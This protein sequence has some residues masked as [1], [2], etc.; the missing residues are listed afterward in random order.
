VSAP[1]SKVPFIDLRREYVRLKGEIDAAVQ[2][3][4]TRGYFI[5]GPENAA[6]EEEFAR[7]C[8]ARHG[9]LLGSGTDAICLA[10]R[11]AGIG[12]GDEVITV[13]HTAVATIAA[14]R[15]TGAQ[16]VLVDVDD[17]TLNVDVDAV[18]AALT[19]RT[20]AVIA[21]HLYG[22]PADV[23]KLAALTQRRGIAL[24]E[25]AAQAQGA[26]VGGK[27]V[28]SFGRVAAFS[29]YP[30]KNIGAYGDGG[31][32]VTNDDEIAKQVRLLRQYG[33]GKVRYISEIE[34][35]NSRMDEMQAAIVRVKLRVAAEDDRAR[36]AHARAYDEGLGDLPLR[37]PTRSPD[38]KHAFHLYVVRTP[39]RD[40]LKKHL[41][42]RGIDT[43]IHYPAAVHQQGPYREM[44]R[45]ALPVTER[46]VGEILS[47]PLYPDLRRDELDL[48]V[49]EVRAFF[50]GRRA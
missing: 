15:L 5:L 25:D 14:I 42:D 49:A 11:A 35:T 12:P 32:I 33:W 37:L 39:E 23:A 17:E 26:R 20:K 40:A 31:A 41:A 16:P 34:G 3:V 19:S 43:A 29:F 24:I 6:L 21:V 44:V 48:V 4:L 28:G 45:G 9:I 22:R 2:G 10:L 13:S 36:Q 7:Y 27:A 1:S 18:D 47:L 30:T 46:A 50:A 38:I 8:D